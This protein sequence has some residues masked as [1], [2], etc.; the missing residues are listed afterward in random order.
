MWISLMRIGRHSCTQYE[1]AA[2]N[3]GEICRQWLKDSDSRSNITMQ[4]LTCVVGSIQ[5]ASTQISM[6]LKMSS[7]CTLLEFHSAKNERKR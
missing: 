1:R 7:T 5:A 4:P 3:M 2:A 6:H